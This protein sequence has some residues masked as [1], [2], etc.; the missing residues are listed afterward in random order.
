MRK[1]STFLIIAAG[2]LFLL[3]F[4]SC[5]SRQVRYSRQLAGSFEATQADSE[6]VSEDEAAEEEVDSGGDDMLAISTLNTGDEAG[7]EV[8]SEDS[9]SDDE[10]EGRVAE[11]SGEEGTDETRLPEGH[12]LIPEGWPES[13]PV[14]EEF[15]VKYSG[16]DETGMQVVAF[17]QLSSEEVTAFYTQI[18]EWELIGHITPRI[19]EQEET[20][21]SWLTWIIELEREGET[22]T[23]NI[24]DNEEERILQLLYA[25]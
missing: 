19:D 3:T 14:M 4:V 21:E 20:G 6:V 5:S 22:A 9:E 12:E 8:G 2:L 17:G 10:S 15:T 1:Y 18:P 13:L 7:H 25:H 16:A 11:G 23:V 24:I